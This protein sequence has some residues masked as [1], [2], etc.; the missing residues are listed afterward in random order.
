L[1]KTLFLFLL[2]F[3][4]YSYAEIPTLIE[5]H[6]IN[7]TDDKHIEEVDKLKETLQL[8]EA[9]IEQQKEEDKNKEKRCEKVFEIYMSH[10]YHETERIL[11]LRKIK[12]I[13]PNGD[14]GPEEYQLPDPK[15]HRGYE[16]CMQFYQEKSE[17]I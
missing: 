7:E 12:T 1:K 15:I 16:A 2:F 17:S 14:Y 5:L 6:I 9:A 10:Y 4:L 3:P 13:D 8:L 11:T